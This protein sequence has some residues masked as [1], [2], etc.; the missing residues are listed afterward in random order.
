[1]TSWQSGSVPVTGGR[2]A[3]HRTGGDKP[4]LVLSHGLTDN[5]LCWTRLA[6][7]LEADFDVVMLDARGHGASS[8]MSPDTAFDPGRDI[9]EA[10]T[11][12]GL[13]RPVVMGHSVGG[14]AT[15]EYAN[16]HPGLVAKVIL[17]DPAFTPP[18]DPERLTV[19][20]QRFRDHVAGFMA[21]TEAQIIAQ[22]RADTPTWH[23]DDFPAW[24]QAKR[25]VDPEAFPVYAS[26]WQDHVAAI[27][28]PT[29]VIHGEAALG[30]LITPELAA[31]IRA[32]NPAIRTARIAGA[33]HN[34]RRENFAGV[35]AEVR[36]FLA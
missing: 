27:S 24:A 20:R 34:V 9:A 25:Q 6:R 26:P 23:A 32:L 18:I 14:R 17:E 21:R 19:R 30:S 12:L 13:E 5:G 2:L 8:R 33:A 10:I 35:L 29:L 16:A 7:A 4:A 1:M 11:A 31:E 28:A 36:A 22:G 15:A 3:Y